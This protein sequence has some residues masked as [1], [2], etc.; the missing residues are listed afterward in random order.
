M[1]TGRIAAV[2]ADINVTPL[3]DVVL[4]LLIIFMIVTERINDQVRLPTTSN[5]ALR[6]PSQEKLLVTLDKDG[7]LRIEGQLVPASEIGA[8]LIEAH[9]KSPAA[10]VAVKADA[11]LRYGDVKTALLSVGDAGFDHVGLI[12]KPDARAPR[13]TG[14]PGG[15]PPPG[16]FP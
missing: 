3:V 2:K 9:A 14:V 5:P 6:P 7:T 10:V 12:T 4:V 15:A 11:S 8:R 1:Q 16:T 13:P